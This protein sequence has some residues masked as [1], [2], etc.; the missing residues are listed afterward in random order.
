M[1]ITKRPKTAVVEYRK[2]TKIEEISV[3]W[4]PACRAQYKG[5]GPARNV[6]RFKCECGQELI[7][8]AK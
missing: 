8:K 7:V 6:T 2:V 4:C 3:Y 5:F 1:A